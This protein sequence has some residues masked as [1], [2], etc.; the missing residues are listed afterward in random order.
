MKKKMIFMLMLLLVGVGTDAKNKPMNIPFHIAE[1]YF[2]NNDIQVKPSYV[3]TTEK[4][5]NQVFGCAPVMGKNG[6]PTKID[7]S[8]EYVIAICKPE[9]D[10]ETSLN[11]VSLKRATG[12][13]LVFTYRTIQGAKMTYTI[14]PCLLIVVSKKYSGKVSFKEIRTLKK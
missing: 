8:K 14:R 7:F 3:I 10:T 2:V 5:F 12:K 1:R 9:I 11:A 4:I 6:M 13:N